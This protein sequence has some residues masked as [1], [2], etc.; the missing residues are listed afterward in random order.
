[1]DAR[2]S[3]ADRGSEPTS[4]GWED[5]QVSGKPVLR[6]RKSGALLVATLIAFVGAIPLT[7]YGWQ[8]LPILILPLMAGVWAWRAGT[9]VFEEGVRVRALAGSTEI[10]WTRIVALAPDERGRISAQLDNGNTLRLT[11]VTR[12]NLPRVLAVSNPPEP[13]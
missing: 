13:D 3:N 7:D 10:P 8:F 12:E 9:D 5:V 11:G 4:P 2:R 1:M 6:I